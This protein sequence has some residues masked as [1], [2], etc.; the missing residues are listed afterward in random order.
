[1]FRKLKIKIIAT[2]MSILLTVFVGTLVVIYAASYHD[3]INEHFNMME[4]YGEAYEKGGVHAPAKPN[5]NHKN[6][7][8]TYVLTTFYSVEL[9]NNGSINK[10]VNEESSGLSDEELTVL[11]SDLAA[12]RSHYGSVDHMLY[13]VTPINQGTLVIF[14]NNIITSDNFTALFR[15]A[16]IFGCCAIVILFFFSCYLADRMIRPLEISFARQ[17]QFISDAGHELKT[18]LSVV[19][20]N[21]EILAREVGENKWL[22]NIRYENGKMAGASSCNWPGPKAASRFFQN[23]TSVKLLQAMPC[24][25]KV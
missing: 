5:G 24:L 21:A 11:A 18:P 6:R 20:A 3:I 15:Y 10:V 23:L 16:L 9:A 2:I 7:E 19:S 12:S 14:L 4:T 8:E 13:L 17:K 1:M 25:L 22:N